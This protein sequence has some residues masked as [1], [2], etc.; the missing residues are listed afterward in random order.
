MRA[1]LLPLPSQE[2]L[3][4]ALSYESSTGIVRWKSS[5]GRQSCGSVAGNQKRAGHYIGFKGKRYKTARIII[6]MVYNQ[7]PPEVDHV[8]LDNSNN[9]LDNLRPAN[10]S[11]NSQNQSVRSHNKLG[12][13]GVY[14]R[15]GKYVMQIIANKKRKVMIFDTLDEARNAYNKESKRMHGTYGRL[16]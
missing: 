6:K 13:K 11:Q 8:D 7:E 10:R 5:H 16:A 14:L 15:N 4:E 9:A 1:L 12:V 3:L 2:E